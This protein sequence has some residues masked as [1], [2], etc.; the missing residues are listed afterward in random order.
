MISRFLLP[1]PVGAVMRAMIEPVCVRSGAG[2]CTTLRLSAAEVPPP[3]AGV[4]TLSETEPTLSMGL[5]GT[6]PVTCVGFT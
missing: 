4:A 3:G 6:R 5:A 2:A 1:I